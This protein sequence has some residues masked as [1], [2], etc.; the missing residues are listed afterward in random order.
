ME[1]VMKVMLEAEIAASGFI[2]WP[3][4]VFYYG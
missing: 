4:V 2:A 3:N 1:K